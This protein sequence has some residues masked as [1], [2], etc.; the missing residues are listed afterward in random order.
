MNLLLHFVFVA[1]VVAGTFT[2]WGKS[3]GSISSVCPIT[4]DADA[5]TGLPP[6]R[7][8]RDYGKNRNIS[9]LYVMDP[10]SSYCFGEVGIDPYTNQTLLSWVM[11]LSDALTSTELQPSGEHL[12]VSN[13]ES[14]RH[15]SVCWQSAD[16]IW[17]CR[18][19]SDNH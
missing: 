13:G 1:G 10:I 19:R 4:C 5:G 17:E 7:E 2:L 12:L 3:V 9:V 15:A 8:G 14:E 18:R 6:Y 16:E 11:G